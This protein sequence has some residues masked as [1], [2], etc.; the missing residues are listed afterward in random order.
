ML[1]TLENNLGAFSDAIHD[2]TDLDGAMGATV[3]QRATAAAIAGL[4]Y[5]NQKKDEEAIGLLKRSIELTPGEPAYLALAEI[6]EMSEKTAEAVKLLE[7]GT[8][9][10]P[11][12]QKIALAFGRTLVDAGDHQRAAAVLSG[13]TQQGSADVEAWHWLAQAETSLG[14]FKKATETLEQLARRQPDYPLID[15][16][17]AQSLLKWDPPDNERAL[18]FLDRAAKAA[19]IEPDV[20]F[21]RGKIYYSLGRYAEAVKPLERAIELRPTAS[22]SYYQLGQALQKLGREAEA[23]EQ[24]DKVRHLKSVAP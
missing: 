8:A 13:I 2:A 21:M 24:F 17:I 9:V 23:K 12:S 5:K 11:G 22:A 7:Q 10:L 20:Y 15:V 4:A 1:A 3:A 14:D 18:R 19:P 16:M 6:Y